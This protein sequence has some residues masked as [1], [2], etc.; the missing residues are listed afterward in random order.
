[1]P[2]QTEFLVVP[3]FPE[4]L[5]E[6]L[7]CRYRSQIGK[8][9]LVFGFDPF[10]YGFAFYVLHPPVRIRNQDAEVVVYLIRAHR[11]GIGKRIFG[12][13][14]RRAG[15]QQSNKRC[16]QYRLERS[17]ISRMH[18][19]LQESDIGKGWARMPGEALR[20]RPCTQA[21]LPVCGCCH[22]TADNSP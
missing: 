10:S 19:C 17:G 2:R 5:D 12:M 14:A 4:S 7:A 13:V 21:T 6:R 3:Y 16:Q 20:Y 8:R 18:A 22:R 9:N 1:M 15:K 11:M